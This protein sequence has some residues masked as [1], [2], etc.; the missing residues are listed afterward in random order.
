MN[1]FSLLS[2]TV[3]PTFGTVLTTI[4]FQRLLASSPTAKCIKFHLKFW[5]SGT[6]E[7]DAFNFDWS[8]DNNWLV[9]P[10]HLINRI[11]FH[12][13]NCKARDSP[14]SLTAKVA[15]KR[16]F[17]AIVQRILFLYESIDFYMLNTNSLVVTSRNPQFFCNLRSNI[18]IFHSNFCNFLEELHVIYSYYTSSS[19]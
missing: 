12:L 19:L 1:M 10:I 11:V 3:L 18:N 5:W 9:P 17:A 6:F 7:V 2:I 14:Y 8:L 4:D 16:I 15:Q 13:E